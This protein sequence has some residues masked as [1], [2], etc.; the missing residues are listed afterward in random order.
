[1]ELEDLPP[2]LHP[3]LAAATFL[4]SSR[5]YYITKSKQVSEV[6]FNDQPSSDGQSQPRSIALPEADV[7]GGPVGAAP[8]T[9]GVNVY[10]FS[11]GNIT[12]AGKN[13]SD[14]W[15]TVDTLSTSISTSGDEGRLTPSEGDSISLAEKI[16][17]TIAALATLVTI[18]AAWD[19]WWKGRQGRKGF[20]GKGWGQ[21]EE[22]INELQKR[23]SEE[24]PLTA[25]EHTSSPSAGGAPQAGQR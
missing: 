21:I 25:T 10:Y 5:L 19:A 11:K 18:F 12:V 17:I 8:S 16:G 3:N 4:S 7:A 13:A 22:L 15:I 14:D 2:N 6:L 1:M 24:L 23:K 9:K 20:V